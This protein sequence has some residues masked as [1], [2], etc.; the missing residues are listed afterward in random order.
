[1]QSLQNDVLNRT[2]GGHVTRGDLQ[3]IVEAD[4]GL[5]PLLI[6]GCLSPK[7]TV[8]YSC[9][10]VLVELT[11]KY[12]NKLYPY[13]EKFVALLDSKYRII[14]WNAL[15]AIANLT[16]VDVDCK[17]DALFD[18]YYSF[19]DSEYMVTVAN[20]V[21]NT[22]T[23]VVNK[24]YLADRLAF[25]LLKVQNLRLTPHLTEECTRVIAQKAIRTFDTLMKYT[26]NKAILFA[27]AEKYQNSNRASLRKEAQ[28][29]LKKWQ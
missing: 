9:A 24:P 8:R 4:F 28:G 21:S 6:E 16:S 23:V 17:F 18:R 1:M 11:A 15:A 5:V 29:F 27:F 26:Q 13:F 14:T 10:A 3:K 2:A 19:L 25:E 12:P 7:G 20:T 22:A